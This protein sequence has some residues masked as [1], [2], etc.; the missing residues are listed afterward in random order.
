MRGAWAH[1]VMH[2]S[3]SAH[4]D[5]E[6]VAVASKLRDDEGGICS[7]AACSGLACNMAA[8]NGKCDEQEGGRV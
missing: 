3:K 5:W 2:A 7:G 4:D 8:W 1:E 6:A